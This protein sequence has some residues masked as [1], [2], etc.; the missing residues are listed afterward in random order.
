MSINRVKWKSQKAQRNQLLD[1]HPTEK[2]AGG[3]APQHFGDAALCAIPV[4]SVCPLSK[5]ESC[6]DC[7]PPVTGNFKTEL[8]QTNCFCVNWFYQGERTT[9]KS[10]WQSLQ[11][12]NRLAWRTPSHTPQTFIPATASDSGLRIAQEGKKRK[13]WKLFFLWDRSWLGSFM[14]LQPQSGHLGRFE[15]AVYVSYSFRQD[16]HVSMMKTEEQ[17]REQKCARA[18]EVQVQ[19]LFP[20][21]STIFYWPKQVTRQP[22]VQGWPRDPSSQ[23]E[24]L[25]HR[26]NCPHSHHKECGHRKGIGLGTFLKAVSLLSFSGVI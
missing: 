4:P 25:Y 19:N 16:W 23:W 1:W 10:A 20:I 6:P 12:A 21:I 17:K 26:Q 14:Y 24:E 15:L 13:A 2:A 11:I 7:D 18:L 3:P 8:E 9:G 22:R 5:K